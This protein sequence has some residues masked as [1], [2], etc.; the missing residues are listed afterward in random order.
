MDMNSGCLSDS[1]R[2]FS[3]GILLRMAYEI[4]WEPEGVVSQFAE[5]VSAREFI[6]SVEKVQG[7]SRFDDMRYVINEIGRAHV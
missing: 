2:Y 1:C 5:N 6:R 3:S 7:D 4:V